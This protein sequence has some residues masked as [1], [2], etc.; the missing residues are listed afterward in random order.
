M[1]KK[2]MEFL[3]KIL[4]TRKNK[5]VRAY[6]YFKDENVKTQQ[7]PHHYASVVSKDLPIHRA[8]I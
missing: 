8:F 6:K 7:P 2:S 4:E 3:I 1:N 5:R